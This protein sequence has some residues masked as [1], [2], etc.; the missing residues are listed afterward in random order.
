PADANHTANT[1]SA[2]F[3][4]SKA[5]ST[6]VVT[7]PAATQIFT[8]SAITPCSAAV[9]GAGGLSLTPTPTYSNNV[10]VGI[11]TASA[12][13]AFAGDGNHTGSNGSKTFSIGYGWSGF[14]QPINDTAH[15]TGL[16]QSKFK[17]G[18]TIPVKFVIKNAA[19]ASVQQAAPNPYFTRS[20]YL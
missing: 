7:C 6:T 11:N 5:A 10:N 12:S 16:T 2:T 3:T 1:G 8:G 18:Q 20:G 9:T 15:Q 13:H 14:L 4:I 17:L 19:G